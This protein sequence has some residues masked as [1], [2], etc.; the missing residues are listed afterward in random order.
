MD[1]N[2]L[3]LSCPF[4]VSLCS[5]LPRFLA[6]RFYTFYG[7]YFVGVENGASKIWSSSFLIQ[8]GKLFVY[9]L[10]SVWRV[11]NGTIFNIYTV[12]SG[13]ITYTWNAGRGV[14][15]CVYE[16]KWGAG[17]QIQG[18]KHVKYVLYHFSHISRPLT[19]LILMSYHFF[20][21][22]FYGCSLYL[23][24]HIS[25]TEG[26]FLFILVWL[27]GHPQQCSEVIPGL[28]LGDHIW[29]WDSVCSHH[30]H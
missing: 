14:M 17:N 15:V 26:F 7:C 11:F 18:L 23:F 30:S 27:L 19:P 8:W 25:N 24:L 5:L 21:W 3:C 13:A 6:S 4:L 16:R 9:I 10:H 20:P 28:C 2:I 12:V 29:C 1:P 22:F